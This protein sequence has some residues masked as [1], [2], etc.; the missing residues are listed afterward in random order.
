MHCAQYRADP[1]ATLTQSGKVQFV[2]SLTT[3]QRAQQGEAGDFRQWQARNPPSGFWQASISFLPF[4]SLHRVISA[5][6]SQ[7]S[8]VSESIQ[9]KRMATSLILP[10]TSAAVQ[11][12]QLAIAFPDFLCLLS[13]NMTQPAHA[14]PRLPLALAPH[15]PPSCRTSRFFLSLLLP[16]SYGQPSQPREPNWPVNLSAAIT[17][18]SPPPPL[19][20]PLGQFAS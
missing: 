9:R 8:R 6:S 13:Q 4:R 11:L 5:M 3:Q 15:W 19:M 1:R 12:M 10:S 2:R 16:S 7:C 20:T 17:S 14:F 18:S